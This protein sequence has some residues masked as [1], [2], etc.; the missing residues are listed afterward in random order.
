MNGDTDE[1]YKLPE[2]FQDI[3]IE[4]R[5][6]QKQF[7]KKKIFTNVTNEVRLESILHSHQYKEEHQSDLTR[8]NLPV[9]YFE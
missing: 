6:L 3:P 9:F 5:Q 1:V 4:F 7:E 8:G 2:Q